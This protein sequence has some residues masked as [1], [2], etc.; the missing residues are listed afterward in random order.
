VNRR[1]LLKERRLSAQEMA[2]KSKWK[3][4]AGMIPIV[5]THQHLWDLSRFRLPWL[6]GG[7]PLATDHLMRDYLK[8]CDGLNVVRTVYMEVDVA[9]EQHVAEAEYVLDLCRRDDNPMVGAVIGGRPG[10]DGF[11]A[12]AARYRGNP[13]V[14]G[15]RQ[16]LHGGTERGT[17]LQPDFVRDIRLLG[18]YGMRFDLCLRPEELLDGAKLIDLCP[19]TRFVLDHCGNASV[20]AKDRSQWQ[21]DIAEVAKRTNVL[22][23]ISGIVASAK[24]G[25]W[26]ADD[27]AP[28]VRHCA[29]VFGSDRLLFAS[30]WPVCTLAATYRQWVEALQAIV[31]AWSETDRRNLFH[32]N[33]VRFYE[34]A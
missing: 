12:Y 1:E 11:Q 33:A 6:D 5:D 31:Q 21:K 27:L 25:A 18:E 10:T 26:T 17:C 22:C 15:V 14:K 9:P 3:G 20:Q 34:L 7:G 16:V 19:D 32:D 23:K 2:R 13:S 28:I 8:A 30:D 24:P 4:R 29:E